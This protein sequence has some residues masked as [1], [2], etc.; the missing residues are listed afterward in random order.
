MPLNGELDSEN[1]DG[2]VYDEE[3]E[4]GRRGDRPVEAGGVPGLVVGGG[5]RVGMGDP[6]RD[7]E[8]VVKEWTGTCL[9]MG[10]FWREDVR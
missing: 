3:E 7:D 9:P 4:E 2:R 5:G 8:G 1:T 10:E 6:V